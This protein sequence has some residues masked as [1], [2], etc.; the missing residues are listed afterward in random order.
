S[1][2]LALVCQPEPIN[3]RIRRQRPRTA[4]G[5]G[6]TAGAVFRRSTARSA[7]R[8]RVRSNSVTPH[9][10]SVRPSSAGS[11]LSSMWLDEY[12]ERNRPPPPSIGGRLACER[13]CRHRCYW[14]G[15][16]ARLG[17]TQEWCWCFLQTRRASS[18]SDSAGNGQELGRLGRDSEGRT[19]LESR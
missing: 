4:D 8:S 6:R 16:R 15:R 1:A 11:A 17:S 13:I 18:C 5:S 10:L 9:H 14:P 19:I 7:I 12:D 3:W 2:R